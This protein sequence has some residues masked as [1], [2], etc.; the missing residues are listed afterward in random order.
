MTAIIAV[1]DDKWVHI[2]T[3]SRRWCNRTKWEDFIKAY[4]L[5]NKIIVACSWDTETIDYVK[6]FYKNRKKIEI[7]NDCLLELRAH[8]INYIGD[9]FW[10]ILSDWKTIKLVEKDVIMNRED[11]ARS[12]TWWLQALSAYIALSDT[13]DYQYDI[14]S[15]NHILNSIKTAIYM[16]E[17]CWWEAK[18]Y[19]LR[20][21]NG[22]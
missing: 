17:S 15:E 11:Y 4:I 21:P 3:D 1:L 8:L 13:T 19:F 16:D 22:K 14:N 20:N 6:E 10:I 18:Y 2:W 7:T 9:N 5:G 12:W